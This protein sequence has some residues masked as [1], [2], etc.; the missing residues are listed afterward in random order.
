MTHWEV[1]VLNG[2][3]A[4]ASWSCT[5]LH[6]VIVVS[7]GS[8]PLF[9]SLPTAFFMQSVAAGQSPGFRRYCFV[10]WCHVSILILRKLITSPAHVI[11][12]ALHSNLFARLGQ[13]GSLDSLH[14]HISR[15]PFPLLDVPVKNGKY[16]TRTRTFHSVHVRSCPGT[17]LTFQ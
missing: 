1:K 10:R 5:T 2:V 7:P 6:G 4:I 16:C 12:T 9:S 8:V 3:R 11:T 13:F 14:S 17:T 15:R